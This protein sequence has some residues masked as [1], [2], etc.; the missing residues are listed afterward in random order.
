MVKLKK[1]IS[2][3]MIVL[4]IVGIT[5]PF[6][7]VQGLKTFQ[8]TVET[9][10][11]IPI[12][13]AGV[14]L[15]DSLLNILGADT[16]DSNGQYSF[17][18]TLSGYSPYYLYVM[19][20]E[21]FDTEIESVTTGGTYDF[22][23]TAD[24]YKLAYLFY[25]NNAADQGPMERYEGILENEG[26]IVEIIADCDDVE[27]KCEDIADYVIFLDTIFVYVMGH[28]DYSGGNS[29]TD[30]D[31]METQ[32]ITSEEFKGYLDDWEAE[33]VFLFVDSCK[34]GGWPEDFDETP[35]LVMSSS[36]TDNYSYRHDYGDGMEGRFSHDFFYWVDY[37][38]TAVA[39]FNAAK[40]NFDDAEDDWPSYP[41][42][43]DYS[44]YT[45][46]N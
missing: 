7:A 15:Y 5:T 10:S 43:E 39:A 4:I 24:A 18:A 23:L 38:Y 30:F 40:V 37:G 27:G 6:V 9:P 36:D 44:S 14:V 16:T 12:S 13:G 34:S 3:F 41:Q 17:T 42:K 26:F 35:Y 22:E 45:W 31:N 19:R 8:G 2:L 21:R 29:I 1:E 11:E 46:F 33:R 28:G 32:N 25:A 20:G